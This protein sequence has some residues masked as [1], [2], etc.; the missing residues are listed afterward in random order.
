M[1]RYKIYLY[2]IMA[3]LTVC[4]WGVT[5]V[6]T[7]ILISYDLS[8]IEIF[9]YRFIL[10]YVCIWFVAPRHIFAKSKKDELMFFFMGLS[11]GSIYFLAENTALEITLASNV[12]LL[13]CTAPILTSILSIF[14]YKEEKV[15][16]NLICGSLVALLGVGLV[17]FNGNFIFSVNPKGDLL[18]L[19]A[20]LMWAFYSIIYKK[21]DAKYSPLFMTRKIFFYGIIT[22]LPFLL[23]DSTQIHIN[24]LTNSVV[25][26]NLLFLGIVASLICFIMWNSALKKLG[27]LRISNYIYITPLVTF[28]AS[29]L[30]IDESITIM[31]IVGALLILFGVYMS[32]RKSQT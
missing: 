6:S 30:I 26:L 12:A 14:F 29:Y 25:L 15:T 16:K 10:A 2:H 4:V 18:T 27:V 11:G 5:F 1:E 17:V 23:I 24:M 20:A 8:P 7:K 13:I 28:I 32:E 3:I 31:A 9:I 21:I 22:T 19:F